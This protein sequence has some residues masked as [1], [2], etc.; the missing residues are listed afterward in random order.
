[1]KGCGEILDDLARSNFF[2]IIKSLVNQLKNSK[3]AGEVKVIINALKWKYTAR[4]HGYLRGLDIFRVLHE[5]NNDP[6]N[7]LRLCW[8]RTIKRSIITEEESRE[9]QQDVL[10]LF[11]QIYIL[12]IGR[13]V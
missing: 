1:M 10:Q 4:D 8:G 11:E 7:I 13:I 2:S 5:G 3:E 6:K 9:I 12:T